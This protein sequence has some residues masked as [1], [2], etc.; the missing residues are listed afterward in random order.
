MTYDQNKTLYSGV[1]EDFTHLRL[2]KE[3]WL[4][5]KN[6]PFYNALQ[7][8]FAYAITC[9]KAFKGGQW[10]VVFIDHGYFKGDA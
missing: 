6:D 9:H 2:K 10:P 5:V 3:R 1:A 7:V 8:K 4:A